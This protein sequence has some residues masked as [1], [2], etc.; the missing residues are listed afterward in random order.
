[1]LDN[2]GGGLADH[3]R[4]EHGDVKVT[5]DRLEKMMPD[6]PEWVCTFESNLLT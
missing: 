6:H 1:M 3:A 4:H 2:E 5:L